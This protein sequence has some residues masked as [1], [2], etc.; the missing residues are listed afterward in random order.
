MLLYRLVEPNSEVKFVLYNQGFLKA[1]EEGAA[2]VYIGTLLRQNNGKGEY[3]T[4]IVCPSDIEAMQ[5]INEQQAVFLVLGVGCLW[6]PNMLFSFADYVLYVLSCYGKISI[7]ICYGFICNL[8]F[9]VYIILQMAAFRKLQLTKLF[10]CYLKC[11]VSSIVKIMNIYIKS[12]QC[13][14]VRS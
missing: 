11:S 13:G 8:F 4:A 5:V 10:H 9:Y 12:Q 3:V 7:W 2:T 1:S 14:Q 6:Q